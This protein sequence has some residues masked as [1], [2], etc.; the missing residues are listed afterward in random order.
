MPFAKRA[1]GPQLLCRYR[2]PNEEGLVF[3]DLVSI[4]NVALSR[5]LRQLSDLARHACSIFQELE[6]DLA[7]TSQRVRGLQG[8][9]NRLQQA[10]SELDPKQ[11]AVPVESGRSSPRPFPRRGACD[12]PAADPP[13]PPSLPGLS[14]GYNIAITRPGNSPVHFRPWAQTSGRDGVLNP[15]S[16]RSPVQVDGKSHGYL[17]AK[18]LPVGDVHVGSKM[19]THSGL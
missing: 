18:S 14:L 13:F 15:R 16:G 17:L 2:I 10:C 7:T 9:V 11:E 12:S 8:K 3:E 6:S 4:S 1:V 5:T 19:L